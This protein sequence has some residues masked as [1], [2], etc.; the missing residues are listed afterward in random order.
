ENATSPLNTVSPACTPSNW[1]FVPSAGLLST[2]SVGASSAMQNLLADVYRVAKTQMPILILGATGSGKE[3]I[4]KLIQYLSTSTKAPF[5]DVN[6]AAIPEALIESQFFG[7]VKGAFSGAVN[8]QKGYFSIASNGILF[9]DEIAE[10]PLL[11]Q[12][13]LLRVIE[14][15]QYRPIGENVNIPFTGRIIVATHNDLENSVNQQLFREDLYH[16][17][18]VIPLRVPSLKERIEDIPALANH[19]VNMHSI[20]IR[21]YPKTLD[22]LKS[23][24]WAGNIRELKNTIDRAVVISDPHD[25][26][27]Q[28]INQ[29]ITS[30]LKYTDKN[31]ITQLDQLALSLLDTDIPN[32]LSAIEY[33]TI[34]MAMLR[35]N[36]NKSSA[37]RE[38]GVHRKFIERKLNT[39]NNIVN[40]I[41]HLYKQ[42]KKRMELHDYQGAISELRHALK[43]IET[44]P[45]LWQDEKIKLD[46]ILRLTI[47]LRNTHGWGGSE[48]ISLY[49]DTENLDNQ[50]KSPQESSMIQFGLWGSKLFA[51]DLFSALKIAEI[52]Y[53]E[54]KQLNNP[55]VMAQ[56]AI[57]ITNTHFW[58]GDYNNAAYY[59]QHF[60][61]IYCHDQRAMINNG[62][63]L[64][65][66]YLLFK[67]LIEFQTGKVTTAR[68]SANEL[69]NYS[70]A[71]QHSFSI[72]TAI[73]GAILLYYKSSEYNKCYALAEQLLEVAIEHSFVFFQGFARIF[74]GHQQGMQ[75]HYNKARKKIIDAYRNQLNEGKGLL[76]NS[77]FGIIV[78][79]I[80]LYAKEYQLGLKDIEKSIKVSVEKNELCYMPEQL[81]MRG[82]LKVLLGIKD[83]A[84]Q[85]FLLAK[86]K[87][88]Q[89]GSYP[90]ELKASMELARFYAEK[91]QSIE[92]K[93]LLAPIVTRYNK[94]ENYSVLK[95]ARVLLASNFDG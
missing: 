71:I 76:F 20:S 10:L 29:L 58:M 24:L 19:F 69:L 54:G 89:M 15:G 60:I 40:E 17:L 90:G 22:S 65:V 64:F 3:L 79:D 66:S 85:D 8:N 12:R 6:C 93:M 21:L 83:E 72:A 47:C 41:N 53:N 28:L 4:A 55:N 30:R 87:A 77:M 56:A 18:N 23:A 48:L 25:I 92:V 57:S 31:P 52:Y 43:Q 33:A 63:D 2:T 34:K 39:F 75:G 44:Y 42:T 80:A 38:L 5:I 11:Q 51:L 45:Q 46:L 16:R 70:Q 1:K 82:R 13:K 26:D 84:H 59:L 95:S 14:T 37:A 62:Y 35:A 88:L 49:T 94:S 50:L 7:H 74:L 32:K 68:E 36:G 91:N 86:R 9:L 27:E 78:A 61:D 73:Q 67:P 81:V